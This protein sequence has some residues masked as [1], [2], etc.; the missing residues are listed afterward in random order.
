MNKLVLVKYDENKLRITVEDAPESD[1]LL[2]YMYENIG[3]KTVELVYFEGFDGWVNEEG[4]Y[5]SGSPV[6]GYGLKNMPK[7]QLAGNIIFTK[8]SDRD[9]NTT[10]FDDESQDDNDIILKIMGMVSDARFI[11]TVR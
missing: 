11:G 5:D 8:G 6:Y 10:F 9:G 1:K 2:E 4:L 7:A 3:C